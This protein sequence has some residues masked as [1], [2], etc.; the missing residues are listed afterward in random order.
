MELMARTT[1]AAPLLS[2]CSPAGGAAGL[3]VFDAA[4]SI[5]WASQ[6]QWVQLKELYESV[7]QTANQIKQIENQVRQIEGMY[8]KIDQGVEES[9]AART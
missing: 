4:R 3:P 6:Q 1:V 7:R 9:G 8:T 2:S 5:R